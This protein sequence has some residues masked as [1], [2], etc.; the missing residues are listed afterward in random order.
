M[1]DIN[2]NTALGLAAKE[3][4]IHFPDEFGE[5]GVERPEIIRK[6]FERIR[7][8]MKDNAKERGKLT[9]ITFFLS[10]ETPM[11]KLIRYSAHVH[12]GMSM[13]IRNVALVV[14]VLVATAA[15]QATL[16]PPDA[17]LPSND[18]PTSP[19]S[20]SV[21]PHK[22]HFKVFVIMNTLAFNL[23][24]GVMLF[25]LP[26][27]LYSVFLHLALYFMSVS[28][29][30]M[31]HVTG[32]AEHKPM[33]SVLMYISLVL[34]SITYCARFFI[35]SL[36]TVLWSPWWM[37]MP[38][39]MLCKLIKYMGMKDGFNQLELQIRTVGWSDDPHGSYYS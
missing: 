13:D 4:Y 38:Y 24:I 32:G 28:F 29:L 30:T 35:A 10:W 39:R 19:I 6:T 16:T 27:V 31:M 1:E 3:Y 22:H 12:K 2:R 18:D 33:A 7:T 8:E 20:S 23:A 5:F 15:Y 17:V 36:K 25:V 21:V 34:F 37:A 26:F 9:R 11:Q 14:A